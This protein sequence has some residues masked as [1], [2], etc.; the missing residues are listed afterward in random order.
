MRTDQ[1]ACG[2]SAASQAAIA[3]ANTANSRKQ[4]KAH[5]RR[6]PPWPEHEHHPAEQPRRSGRHRRMGLPCV[7][8]SSASC[9]CPISSA[10][11]AAR[12]SKCVR[13]NR[14]RADDRRK[15]ELRMRPKRLR[16]SPRLRTKRASS[17]PTRQAGPSK[18]LAPWSR[19]PRPAPAA[20]SA[21]TATSRG[22]SSTTDVRVWCPRCRSCSPRPAHLRL[23]R[24][25]A[26]LLQQREA[27]CPATPHAG[28]LCPRKASC[29][30]A[31]APAPA[32]S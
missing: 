20:R 15:I 24:P 32:P 1:P 26:R 9:A 31:P 18:A 6:R 30:A 16:P 12:A 8:A 17:R 22:A 11:I 3:S 7:S 23:A 4:R 19:P 25:A 14:R 2:N 28:R 21:A 29:G 10:W 27:C 13:L 5:R